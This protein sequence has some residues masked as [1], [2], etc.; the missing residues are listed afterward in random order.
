MKIWENVGKI[1]LNGSLTEKLVIWTFSYGQSGF[2][3]TQL[4]KFHRE[5]EIE[6]KDVKNRELNFCNEGNAK[7]FDEPK[8]GEEG[9]LHTNEIIES[10]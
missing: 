10:R 1:V 9:F 3:H 4:G 5:L 7:L 8:E 2:R 6:Y